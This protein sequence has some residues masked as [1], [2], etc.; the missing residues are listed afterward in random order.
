M[1]NIFKAGFIL[2]GVWHT[3]MFA[4]LLFPKVSY[5]ARVFNLVHYMFLY[6]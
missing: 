3:K 5:I 6:K 2:T 1:P 4:Q